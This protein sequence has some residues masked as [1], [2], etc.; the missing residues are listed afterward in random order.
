VMEV[1]RRNKIVV[2]RELDPGLVAIGN[3]LY[4]RLVG[5]QVWSIMASYPKAIDR[6]GE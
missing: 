2:S 6:N 4:E 3:L 5:G 1:T